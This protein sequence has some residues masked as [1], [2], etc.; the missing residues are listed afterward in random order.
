MMGVFNSLTTQINIKLY[1]N[2]D[3]LEELMPSCDLSKQRRRG[4]P[5]EGFYGER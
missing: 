2:D 4:R 5:C 1:G 3:Y